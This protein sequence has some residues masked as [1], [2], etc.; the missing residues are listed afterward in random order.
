MIF[1]A[2]GANPSGGAADKI[3]TR[4]PSKYLGDH[5]AEYAKISHKEG[6]LELT[7]GSFTQSSKEEIK[8]SL[9][10]ILET[11]GSALLNL[12]H[13]GDADEKFKF[14]GVWYIKQ[15]PC[16]LVGTYLTGLFNIIKELPD[17]WGEYDGIS[18]L[19]TKKVYAQDR[20]FVL[21]PTT[22]YLEDIGSLFMTDIAENLFYKEIESYIH[23]PAQTSYLKPAPWCT[24]HRGEIEE[25]AAY[26]E[27]NAAT[28]KGG[29]PAE[30]VKTNPPVIC[31]SCF[32]A[33]RRMKERKF[34]RKT[35]VK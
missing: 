29:N 26:F 3:L 32:Y 6:E 4:L 8:K 2:K 7:Q 21:D 14:S 9:I 20:L 1:I 25:N 23:T 16:M 27:I 30:S 33:L 24:I 22:D 34:E 19:L 28:W 10:E 17:N 35:Y 15:T 18:R 5:T 12:E 13:D 11:P 31:E